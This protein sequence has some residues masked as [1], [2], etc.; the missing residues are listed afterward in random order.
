MRSHLLTYACMIMLA[1]PACDYTHG[2]TRLP[3][4]PSTGAGQPDT[5][6]SVAPPWNSLANTTPAV[7]APKTLRNLFCTSLMPQLTRVRHGAGKSAVDRT[8]DATI[9]G[10]PSTGDWRKLTDEQRRAAVDGTH[11]AATGTCPVG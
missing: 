8:V 10:Y 2:D 5:S 3:P 6:E 1:V 4:R 11:D 9:A 7:I